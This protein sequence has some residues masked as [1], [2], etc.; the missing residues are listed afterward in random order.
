MPYY[1][2]LK[3]HVSSKKIFNVLN[4]P[5]RNLYTGPG[6]GFYNGPDTSPYK[7]NIPPLNIFVKELE[8]RGRNDIAN[9]IRRHL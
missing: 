4:S 3:K 1:L 5:S 9:I 8:K 7:S 2:I 6:G